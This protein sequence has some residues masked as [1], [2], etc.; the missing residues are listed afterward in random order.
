LLEDEKAH[1]PRGRMSKVVS[2]FKDG[3]S[4]VLDLPKSSARKRRHQTME[5][6]YKIHSNSSESPSKK[7][8]TAVR[9]LF[10]TVVNIASPEQ[11]IDMSMKSETVCKKVVPCL[12][13]KAVKEFEDSMD[14]INRSIMI[15]YQGGIL[16]KKKYNNIRSSTAY[17]TNKHKKG[18]KTRQTLQNGIHIPKLT[19]Y[20]DL[21][22]FI[23]TI[24]IGKLKPLPDVESEE[25]EEQL[26][27]AIHIGSVISGCYL[28][29]ETRLLQLASMYLTSFNGFSIPKGHFW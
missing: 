1:L 22:K 7:K 24:D 26:D 15:L 16:S 6:A 3:N 12:G 23:K 8:K 21:S 29:L 5:S 25:D 14:N 28:D 27:G 4:E 10:N 13:N 2:S 9:G 18:K 20:K 11:L 17:T 19:T